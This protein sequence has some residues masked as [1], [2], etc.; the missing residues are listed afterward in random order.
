MRQR[1]GA[2]ISSVIFEI[3]LVFRRIDCGPTRITIS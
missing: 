3:S 1:R 2:E